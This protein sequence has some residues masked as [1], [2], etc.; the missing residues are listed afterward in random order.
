MDCE[1]PP[2]PAR[3]ARGSDPA[4]EQ[5]GDRQL[6]QSGAVTLPPAHDSTTAPGTTADTLMVPWGG[7]HKSTG[8]RT[9]SICSMK[10]QP[11]D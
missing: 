5:G 11:C 1:N 8:S 2:F 3:H 10:Q 6:V 4:R 7:S 9:L